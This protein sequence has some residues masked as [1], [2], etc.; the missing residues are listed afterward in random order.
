MESS[1]LNKLP[2]WVLNLSLAVF[3]VAFAGIM[4]LVL[5][6]AFPQL[7]PGMITFTVRMGDVFF[8][9][10][11]WVAIPPNPD[12]ILSVHW[13]GRDQDGFRQPIRSADHYPIIGIGDS[14]T[15]AANAAHPWTDVL[16]EAYGQ[17]VRNL[18]FRGYGPVEQAKVFAQYGAPANPEIVI[19]GYFEGNDLSDAV[20]SQNRQ[21]PMPSETGELQIIP[22]D[23]ETITDRDVRYPMQIDLNGQLH[24]IAF[25]EGYVWA[26]NAT[27]ASFR[28]STN[29]QITEQAWQDMQTADPD[30]CMILAYFPNNAHIYLPYLT[31]EDQITLMQKAEARVADPGEPLQIEFPFNGT[32]DDLLA[33]RHHQRDVIRE[34]A[35]ANGLIF[36]DLVPVL[37]QAA[38]EGQLSYYT[39]DTHWN[40]TGHDLVGRAIADFLRQDPCPA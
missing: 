32:F 28:N 35:E 26:L 33:R 3:G 17:P 37:E 6:T 14:Y 39:Y 27:Q 11:E 25:L 4:V 13:F 5:L 34:R 23:L 18:G 38:D 30:A 36:F 9:T 29:L 31:P 8:H 24:D 16:A 40:Q 20:E 22:R 2:R 10:A 7:R 1:E 15:E 21:L 19:I 12:E